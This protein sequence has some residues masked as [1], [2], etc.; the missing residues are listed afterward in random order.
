MNEN[1]L[2]RNTISLRKHYLYTGTEEMMETK[3]R[4]I[5]E[6][7]QNNPREVFTSIGHLVN[8]EML[9]ICH[10]EMDK[11]VGID[12]VGKEKYEENLDVNLERL[13]EALKNKSYKPQPAKR[14]YI[15]EG[16]G[17]TR[18]LGINAY[19]DKLVQQA[20]KKVLEAV[21]EPRFR[22]CMFGFRPGRSCH[23]AL[24]RLNSIIERGKT[25][26]I[27]DADIEGF[28]ITLTMRC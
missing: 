10:R 6:I 13:A 12:G 4:R 16:N 3:L 27:L 11:A 21:F 2:L 15:P 20:L 19:E 9:E 25:S 5:S 17:K 22:D 14:V 18:P 23:D 24:K 8:K 26:Y 7:S 1:S 28:L